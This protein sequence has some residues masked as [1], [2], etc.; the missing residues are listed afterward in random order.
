MVRSLN[1]NAVYA[2]ARWAMCLTKHHEKDD[3]IKYDC[4]NLI[5]FF[6]SFDS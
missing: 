6:V 2:Y 3:Q 4:I 5:V 1:K